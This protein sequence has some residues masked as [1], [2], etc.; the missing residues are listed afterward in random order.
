MKNK[1]LYIIVLVASILIFIG[2][3]LNALSGRYMNYG[4]YYVLDK[5]TGQVWEDNKSVFNI[6]K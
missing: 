2:L 5:W 1:N 4:K 6:R 3:Y